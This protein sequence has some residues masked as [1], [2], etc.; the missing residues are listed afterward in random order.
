MPSAKNIQN[1]GETATPSDGSIGGG[2]WYTSW[3]DAL[4]VFCWGL[5]HC[6]VRSGTYSG[7][8][9]R[10]PSPQARLQIYWLTL[11][12]RLWSKPHYRSGTFHNDLLKNLRNVAVPKTGIPLSLVC[13]SRLV[14]LP[15]VVLAY[16]MLCLVASLV[17]RWR[18]GHSIGRGFAEQLLHPTD[19]FTFW[20]LNCV[21]A[22]YHALQ[23]GDEGYEM[24]DKLTFL[25]ARCA[26]PRSRGTLRL[27]LLPRCVKLQAAQ[28]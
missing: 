21:L 10:I 11:S 15:F 12:L 25:E 4:L 26:Q 1:V 24:E 20:R 28:S 6:L 3:K 22:S 18:D 14:A 13:C 17:R 5:Q 7:L 27:H 9:E 8:R 2:P 19:W 23:K 16:P